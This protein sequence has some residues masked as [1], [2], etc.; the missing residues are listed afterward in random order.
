M[1]SED[2]SGHWVGGV[3]NVAGRKG[4]DVTPATE[5]SMS[6]RTGTWLVIEPGGKSWG[7][8][9]LLHLLVLTLH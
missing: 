2:A 5:T 8:W 7:N 6:Q 3:R 4:E 9:G 1:Q